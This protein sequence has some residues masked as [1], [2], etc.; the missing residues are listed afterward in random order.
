M[1]AFLCGS[2][3]YGTP[4]ENSDTDI[5]VLVDEETLYALT[6]VAD[7]QASTQMGPE[8]MMSNSRSLRFGKLNLIATTNKDEY[9]A[10]V[11]GTKILTQDK[12]VSRERAVELFK[13]L[14]FDIHNEERCQP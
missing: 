2:R 1:N 12:P 11:Q 5:V 8:Y 4:N 7:R 3:K 13:R 6:E 14:L 10:W 9:H